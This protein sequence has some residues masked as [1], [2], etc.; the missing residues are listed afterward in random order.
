MITLCLLSKFTAKPSKLRKLSCCYS[1]EGGSLSLIFS[2]WAQDGCTSQMR[3]SH[4]RSHGMVHIDTHPRTNMQRNWSNQLHSLKH[5]RLERALRIDSAAV[6]KQDSF[7]YL[8]NGHGKCEL[9][10]TNHLLLREPSTRTE[11]G[12]LSS[13]GT[14]LLPTPF[15]SRSF[16]MVFLINLICSQ[17]PFLS[18]NQN[19]EYKASRTGPQAGEDR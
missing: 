18:C 16:G 4:S 13:L 8:N 14:D 19:L 11:T 6:P 9:C 1:R 2:Q 17:G 3:F 5:G 10:N 12:N 7:I 15:E